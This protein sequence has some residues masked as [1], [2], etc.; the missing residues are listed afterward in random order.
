MVEKMAG[1]ITKTPKSPRYS[2]PWAIDKMMILLEKEGL[3]PVAPDIMAQ[4]LGYS[5]ARN[6]Q[7]A[8]VLG[9]LRMYG[10]ILKAPHRKD[11]I[12]EDIKKFKYTP[13]DEEKHQLAD[14]W[15]KS[16]KL[17]ASVL[18]KYPD[19]LPSDP[20]LRYELIQE[21]NFTEEAANK[22]IKVLKESIEYTQSFA[23]SAQ[24]REVDDLDD[25]E[26]VE[27]EGEIE[28]TPKPANTASGSPTIAPI[29]LSEDSFS[30][31][32]TGPGINSVI[33]IKEEEDLMIVEAMLKKVG[34]KVFA[35]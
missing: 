30:V 8:T 27:D 4:H 33:E 16:P 29:S 10:M 3:H 5:N 25:F 7:A 31:Q 1:K 26:E 32:I 23:A 28:E 13:Y 35:E 22:F 18:T 19:N 24:S 14:K 20:A 2:L 21:F 34:K 11:L 6:G 17:F 15:L 9:T 12:S